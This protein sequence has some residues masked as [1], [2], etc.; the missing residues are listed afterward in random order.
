MAQYVCDYCGD[1][2]EDAHTHPLTPAE[3][4]QGAKLACAPCARSLSEDEDGIDGPFDAA[5]DA[6]MEADLEQQA[7]HDRYM[8]QFDSE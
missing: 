5:F 7:A 3:V 8:A 2:C 6:A 1:K 4:A